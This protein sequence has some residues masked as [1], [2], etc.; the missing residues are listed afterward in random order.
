VISVTGSPADRLI[1][2]TD[3]GT[4]WTTVHVWQAS[5]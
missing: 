1:K 2:T 4:H 3:G 5:A